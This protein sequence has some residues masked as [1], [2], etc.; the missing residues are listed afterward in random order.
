MKATRSFNSFPFGLLNIQFH[1]CAC[2]CIQENRLSEICLGGDYVSRPVAS[3]ADG[4]AYPN[5]LNNPSFFLHTRNDYYR[6][7]IQYDFSYRSLWERRRLKC[8]CVLLLLLT[9]GGTYARNPNATAMS[10]VV[11][12]K[13]LQS[14]DSWCA[15]IARSKVPQRA[16]WD[17]CC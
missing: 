14:V 1:F 11:I 2:C 10:R 7:N 17:L 9:A 13:A 8:Y 12:Q 3:K 15:T 5:R 4:P 16:K 6:W